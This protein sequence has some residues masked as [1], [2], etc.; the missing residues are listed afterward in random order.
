MRLHRRALCLLLGLGILP[1]RGAAQDREAAMSLGAC[2]L[3]ALRNNLGV[4]IEVINPR[5]SALSFSFVKEKYIPAMSFGFS[6]SNTSSAS[7]SW[8]EAAALISSQDQNYS[9]QVSEFI[10][11]GGRVYATLGAYKSESNRSFQTINPRYGSTLTFSVWQPLLRNFGINLNRR[12]VVV[13]RN[14]LNITEIQFRSVLQNTIYTV[15]QSYWNLVYAVEALKV[16][17]QSLDLA[18]DLLA[19]NTREAEVGTIAPIE[20]LN[21]EAEVATREADILQAEASVASGQD[22]LATILNLPREE[23]QPRLARIVP[24]DQPAFEARPL[25][26]EASL[27][28]ALENRA[29]LQVTRIDLENKDLTYA[30]LRNQLLPDLSLSA[31]YWSPGISG[32]Q[33]LYQDNDPLTNVVIGYVPAGAKDSLRDAFRLR[34]RNWSLSL[35]LSIPLNNYLTKDHFTQIKISRDQ[36]VLRLKNL[37]QQV[38][39]EI[40]NSVRDV[41]TNFKRVQAYR[42]ARELAERRLQAEEKK[43]KVGLTTN[44][45][46]LLNQR[47]LATAK[48]NELKAL[49]DYNLSLSSLER[50][51]GTSLETKGI[52]IED[53]IGG[54]ADR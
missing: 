54:G 48:T 22:S 19:K 34:Y 31:S 42:L 47:D 36:S 17:R 50:S 8:I 28:T 23:G 26:F 35:S 30:Y 52:R 3:E 29:D 6:S 7:F 14:N 25:D 9:A 32:T 51:L 24:I 21:A 4:A 46:V 44:Y 27:Q 12:D 11:T 41:E 45:L 10:P 18:K 39:L 49:I 13:A 1:L 37:E 2:I 5:L 53:V 38:Y 15:E 40:K 16:R 33:I 20:V 43:L